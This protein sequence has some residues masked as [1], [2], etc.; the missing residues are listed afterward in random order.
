[1]ARG[2]LLIGLFSLV[3]QYYNALSIPIN[4]RCFDFVIESDLGKGE[5]AF[6]LAEFLNATGISTQ[7]QWE[8]FQCKKWI[9]KGECSCSKDCQKTS[10]CCIDFLWKDFAFNNKSVDE[11]VRGYREAV[12]KST[13]RQSC[14]PLLPFKND[15]S[16]KYYIMV[17]SCLPGANETDVEM[18]LESSSNL[19]KDQVPVYGEDDF[20][21]KNKFCARCNQIFNYRYDAFSVVCPEPPSLSPY[22][23]FT[24]ILRQNKNCHVTVDSYP[25]HDRRC[26]P[27]FCSREHATLCQLNRGDFVD[28]EYFHLSKNIF[29]QK[30]LGSSLRDGKISKPCDYRNFHPGWSKVISLKPVKETQCGPD[31]HEISFGV[32]VKMKCDE[33]QQPFNGVC[34]DMTRFDYRTDNP[35]IRHRLTNASYWNNTNLTNS[36]VYSWTETVTDIKYHISLVGTSLSLFSYLVSLFLFGMVPTLRNTGGLYIM[37]LIIFLLFSDLVFLI[38]V[39]MVLRTSIC[40]WFGILLYWTLLNVLLWSSI[41]AID[42]MLKFM[43]RFDRASSKESTKML[44]LRLLGVLL[45]SSSVIIIIVALQESGT[46]EFEFYRNCWF[47]IF[48]HSLGFYFIPTCI[49][50]FFCFICICLILRSIQHE[51]MDVNETID[52][53]TRKNVNL[54]KICIKLMLILGITEIVGLVQ[55]R[56]STLT[57]N[58]SIFNATFGLVYD[59]IRSFRGVFILVIYMV[60]KKTW[61]SFRQ[62]FEKRSSEDSQS[63]TKPSALSNA[64]PSPAIEKTLY[65]FATLFL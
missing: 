59:M 16:D 34:I 61:R 55:I 65:E 46:V 17:D 53:D 62:S 24:D 8:G 38:N 30:C 11:N 4:S 3:V 18:C 25:K 48:E 37:V 60:N 27:D 58:E 45:A 47:G 19:R 49:G 39:H 36:N 63:R 10:S 51:Q 15:L 42:I 21:Y 64:K 44:R 9:D 40:K 23:T 2:G 13:K 32:C 33:G 14:V 50:Y 52:S 12:F 35:S 7:L 29:C 26:K 22:N 57:E 54:L 1:M 56:R 28:E 5:M 43:K 20:L 31:E 6:P 41:V